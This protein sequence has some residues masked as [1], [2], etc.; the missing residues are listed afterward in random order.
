MPEHLIGWVPTLPLIGALWIAIGYISGSNRGEAGERMTHLSAMLVNGLAFLLMFAYL[1]TSLFRD[2]QSEVELGEWLASGPY[3]IA[4]NFSLDHIGL[5]LGLL[6]TT[7]TLITTR[8]S[9][10]YMHREAGYQRFFIV[11]LIFSSAMSL[12]VLAGN[13]GLAFVAWEMAGISSYLLI[14]YNL[15]RENATENANRALITNRVGD[16]LFILGLF[17]ALTWTGSLN[18]NEM[19]KGGEQLSTLYSGI[20]GICFIIAAM[21]KSALFPFSQW[22]NKALE[23]PTPSSAVFYGSL[24]VH[25]GII[26]LLRMQPLMEQVPVLMWFMVFIGLLTTLYGYLSGLVQTDVKS[27]LIFATTTQVGLI[28]IMMGLGWFEFALWYTIA[29]AIWRAWQFLAAPAFMQLLQQPVRQVPEWISRY[30]RLY[31]ISLQRFWLDQITD[32][33]LVRPTLALARDLHKFDDRIIG[34]IIGKPSLSGVITSLAAWQQ[35]QV[36]TT[37]QPVIQ[38]RGTLGRLLHHLAYLFQWFEEQLILKAGEGGLLNSIRHL[39]HYILHIDLLLSHP[40]YLMLII[41]VTFVV[42]I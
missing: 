12:L 25:A 41:M 20:L 4:L 10:N 26:L 1:I 5:L 23:G 30:Q 38:G 42:I 2:L 11:L 32:W 35:Q 6:V 13:A 22:I 18:W 29:H 17:L 14:A 21:V 33:L 36:S 40:R 16:V 27:A 9:I 31:I 39:G 24:M 28:F 15:E 19:A 7:I 34:R 3:S 8:F 37:T